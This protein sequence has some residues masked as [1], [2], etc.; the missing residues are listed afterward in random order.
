MKIDQLIRSQRK[1]V[2][3]II[4]RDG[5]LL[6]RA[7]QHLAL[8][9][10]QEFVDQKA[11]WIQR[12]RAQIQSASPKNAPVHQKHQFRSGETYMF[13][14]NPLVLQVVPGF[15]GLVQQPE[16]FYLGKK[17]QPKALALFT[18]WYREHARSII[19]GRVAEY[20][21][22]HGFQYQKLRISSARTRW[23]S[24]SSRGTLSFTWRLVMAPMAIIDYVV[25]HELVHLQHPN[26]SRE[27]WA[28]VQEILPDYKARRDWLKQNGV[29]LHID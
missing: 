20:S 16:A 4:E 3:L 13:L 29:L 17:D 28:R 27:F 23:G 11:G 19:S 22:R 18:R 21:Q 24:C 5:R 8:V 2:A 1:T 25:V 9:R 7:P 10:I 26:H 12:T 15:S 14:G 6:V